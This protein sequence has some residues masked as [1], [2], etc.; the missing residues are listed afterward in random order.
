MVPKDKDSLSYYMEQPTTGRFKNYSVRVYICTSRELEYYKKD[1][2]LIDYLGGESIALE[3]NDL[4]SVLPPNIGFLLDI[5]ARPETIQLHRDRIKSL[6]PAN[7]P[8]FNISIQTIHGPDNSNARVFMLKCDKT[9]LSTLTR[10][11]CN[12]NEDYIKFFPWNSY[13]IQQAGQKL[14]IINRQLHYAQSY[15]SLLLTGFQI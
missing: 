10:L 3:Y 4:D 6:L 5:I 9:H 13:A 1:Q 15:C 7:A 8:R 11:F 12:I 14:T 2:D